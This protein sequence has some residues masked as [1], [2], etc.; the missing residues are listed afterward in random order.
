MASRSPASLE[1]VS[2]AEVVRSAATLARRSQAPVRL[3]LPAD[4]LRVRAQRGPLVHALFNLLD[5]ACRVTPPG[6]GVDVV[7]SRMNGHTRIAI[8][9]R[10]PG[11]P[12]GHPRGRSPALQAHGAGYGLVAARRFIEGSGG[13]LSIEDRPGGGSVFEVSLPSDAA[14]PAG[15]TR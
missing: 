6:E 8:Q 2:V 9:D 7:V 13:Q 10:G 12:S 11:L 5:N 14:V 15:G 3:E 4:D 1:D